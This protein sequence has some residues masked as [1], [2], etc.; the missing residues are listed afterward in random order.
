MLYAE[1][2]WH[3]KISPSV[4]CSRDLCCHS[5]QNRLFRTHK[6]LSLPG[7]FPSRMRPEDRLC[8]RESNRVAQRERPSKD[9]RRLSAGR[10]VEREERERAEPII[11]EKL[12]KSFS[13]KDFHAFSH[14]LG[15]DGS[16]GR[17]TFALVPWM[18]CW[19]SQSSDCKM[20]PKSFSLTKLVLE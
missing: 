18:I 5:R 1:D 10:R 13:V 8:Q 14:I 17:V 19:I 20:T 11:F 2:C 9:R 3:S 6:D 4:K 12:P 15:R 7:Q 16:V